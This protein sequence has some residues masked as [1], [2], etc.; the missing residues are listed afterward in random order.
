[1]SRIQ[2][3]CQ[4]LGLQILLLPAML[5]SISAL[6]FFLTVPLTAFHFLL[7]LLIT[8][9]LSLLLVKKTR[10]FTPPEEAKKGDFVKT[11]IVF[12]LLLLAFFFLCSQVMDLSRDGRD[13]HQPGVIALANGWNPVRQP[14]IDT[15]DP[16]VPQ[17]IKE[18]ELLAN[19]YPRASWITAASVGLLT[20]SLEG[21]KLFNFLYLLAAFLVTLNFLSHFQR[22]P[23]PTKVIISAL[24]ALNPVA[25]YQLFSFNNDGQLASFITITIILGFHY[26]MFRERKILFFLLV[27][28]PVLANIKFMGLLY[29]LMFMV[30]AWLTVFVIDRD[31]Q[32]RYIAALGIAVFLGVVFIGFQPY[33]TNWI[34]KGNPLYPA[35]GGGEKVRL[36]A[37]RLIENQVP[38]EFIQGNRFGK[39]FYSVFSQSEHRT[40]QMP[41]LKLPF[42]IND[43]EMSAFNGED[44][45]YGGFGPLFG[46]CLCFIVV[47][48]V[49]VLLVLKARKLVLLFTFIP[50]GII[51][52][53]TLINPE[54]W[55]ARLAPQLWLLPITFI[56]TFYYIG[57]EEKMTYI[58]GFALSILLINSLLVLAH[59]A[60]HTLARNRQIRQQTV[61][62]LQES[63]GLP[64]FQKNS[65]QECY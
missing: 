58:R 64:S 47:G 38:R 61:S 50:A 26:I 55:W 6:F 11:T 27:A 7:A 48:L 29:G 45:R 20:G 60:T 16:S 8:I 34:H 40:D 5:L 12:I 9:G 52:I 31:L 35:V 41:R 22:V 49:V 42:Y 28:F 1:M 25:L 56:I 36:P 62:V 21:G 24:V 39:L 32:A 10:T 43:E 33:I 2:Y 23:E 3:N 63:G 54:A 53:S 59:Y 44:P 19:H 15:N 46:A 57:R 30:L 14:F 51:L 4:I 17:G 65:S 18:N 13:Y 37:A